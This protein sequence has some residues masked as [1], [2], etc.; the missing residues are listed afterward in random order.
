MKL[1]GVGVW[2]SNSGVL[3]V[4]SVTLSMTGNIKAG[5]RKQKENSSALIDIVK[6][7]GRNR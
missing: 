5:S 4:L 1:W 6:K 7:R 3:A 2:K